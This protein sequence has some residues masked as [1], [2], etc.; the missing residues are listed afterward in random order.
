M[1]IGQLNYKMN[2][3]T[4]KADIPEQQFMEAMLNQKHS[5]Q[6]VLIIVSLY[7]LAHSWYFD[8][9]LYYLRLLEINQEEEQD[10]YVRSFK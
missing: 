6:D 1:K 3:L 5:G 4:I 10:K 2:K 8:K 7:A 9:L